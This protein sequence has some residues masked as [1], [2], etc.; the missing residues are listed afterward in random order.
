M[1]CH[2]LRFL[3]DEVYAYYCSTYVDCSYHVGS[4]CYHIGTYQQALRNARLVFDIAH[5]KGIY[6]HILDIGGGFPGVD[7]NISGFGG[8]DFTIDWG[9]GHPK[10]GATF[11]EIAATLNDA[12]DTFFP[13]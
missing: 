4:G 8:G 2:A 9:A 3:I 5:S 6:M 1:S 11:P 10:N 12:L 13:A 7:K